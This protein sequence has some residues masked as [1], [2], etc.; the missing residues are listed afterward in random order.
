MLGVSRS[1]AEGGHSRRVTPELRDT[2]PQSRKGALRLFDRLQAFSSDGEVA[3]GATTANRGRIPVRRD[4][5]AVVFQAIK[6]GVDR[7]EQHRSASGLLDL[8]R[9][10]YSICVV[11]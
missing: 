3:L 8:L 9:N 6:A 5:H 2:R 4:D 11:A 10:R 7:A 1:Q